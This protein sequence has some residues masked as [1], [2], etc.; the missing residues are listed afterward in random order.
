MIEQQVT[1][2]VIQTVLNSIEDIRELQD[3]V[4]ERGNLYCVVTSPVGGGWYVECGGSGIDT[5]RPSLGDTVTWDGNV[6]TVSSP[7]PADTPP[8]EVNDERPAADELS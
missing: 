5:V 6:F 1:I 2:T 7:P 8:V 4:S 3:W